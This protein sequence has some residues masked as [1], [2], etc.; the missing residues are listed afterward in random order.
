MHDTPPVQETC[1]ALAERHREPL[2]GTAAV[3]RSWLCLEQRGPWGHNALVQSHLDPDLG[4]ALDRAAAAAGVRVQLIRRPGRHADEPSA[5]PR[6]VY[7]AHTGPDASWLRTADITD[8][9]DLLGLD[10]DGVGRGEHGGWGRPASGPVLLVCT[11]GR[12][13][14]C[15]ALL[16]RELITDLGGRHGEAV[17]ETTHTGGHRFAPAAVLLPSGYTYGRLRGHTADAALSAAAAGK[18]VLEHCR[19]RSTWSHAGQVAELAVREHVGEYL[20]NALRVT[21]EDGDRVRVEHQDGRAWDVT[22]H[23]YEL[24]PPRP[25]SCGK[26][27]VRPTTHV[28]VSVSAPPEP[29]PRSSAS[30]R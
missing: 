25:N 19:G 22:V 2:P 8:P 5:G 30:P 27:A 7:L 11:N 29:A 18:L 1:A 17:W 12:R 16:G 13:D 3:A 28:A 10:F 14:R 23:Q 15:C 24:D 21:G 6:R 26:A 9:A 20:V 4:R